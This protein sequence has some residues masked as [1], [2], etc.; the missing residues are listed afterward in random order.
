M[1]RILRYTLT[2]ETLHQAAVIPL[3]L[4][5]ESWVCISKCLVAAITDVKWYICT[6]SCGYSCFNIHTIKPWMTNSA[7][8]VQSLSFCKDLS[9]IIIPTTYDRF[10][11]FNILLFFWCSHYQNNN[12][13]QCHICVHIQ[14]CICYGYNFDIVNVL[15]FRVITSFE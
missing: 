13:N 4:H 6:C 7:L 10:V 5:M 1:Y 14:Q 3:W 15:T 11:T 2:N 12:Y 8:S 9:I